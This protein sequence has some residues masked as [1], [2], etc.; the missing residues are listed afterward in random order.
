MPSSLGVYSVALH[1]SPEEPCL[2]VLR[3]SS[4]QRE[5]R[6]NPDEV[7]WGPVGGLVET[8]LGPVLLSHPVD[9]VPRISRGPV[10]G[11]VKMKLGPVTLS[12]PV[13]RVPRISRRPRHSR[14]Q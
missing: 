10:G 11:L 4:D 5:R 14:E 2:V 3:R 7:E 1:Q 9:R 6:A 13:D 8:K 12:Q